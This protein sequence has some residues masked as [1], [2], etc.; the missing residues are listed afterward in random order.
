MTTPCGRRAKWVVV[1]EGE[2]AG[3]PL[4]DRHGP[5][6]IL[7]AAGMKLRRAKPKETCGQSQKQEQAF[8]EGMKLLQEGKS[9]SEVWQRY[10]DVFR[11]DP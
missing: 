4:C 8:F 7:R 11:E 3:A 6:H 5:E 2:V 9:S 10:L 1:V